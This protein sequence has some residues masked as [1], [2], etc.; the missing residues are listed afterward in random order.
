LSIAPIFIRA[1]LNKNPDGSLRTTNPQ[2][3]YNPTPATLQVNLVALRNALGSLVGMQ[4]GATAISF[5]LRGAW[6]TGSEA[7]TC[8]F[9][10][11]TVSGDTAS[12]HNWSVSGS[13][14]AQSI[15]TGS[16]GA[17]V[18]EL[19]AIDSGSHVLSL[20][21]YSWTILAATGGTDTLAPT[22]PTGL[23]LTGGTGVINAVMDP[24]SDNYDNGTQPSGLD[25]Y[26]VYLDGSNVVSQ[27]VAAVKNP[28][29]QLTATNIGNI[30]SPST[31]TASQTAGV[32][33]LSAAG[34]GFHQT[35]TE[36]CLFVGAPLA[37]DASI[38][39]F[40]DAFT[41]ANVF[42]TS[43]IMI[44]ES[45]AQG[46]I[47]ASLY[48][49]PNNNA[50]GWQVKRRSAT[51]GSG[52]NVAS[53]TGPTSGWAR[54]TRLG[55]A[56]I[57]S[58]SADGITFTDQATISLPMS[59]NAFLG[60]VLASQTA[61]T[62]CNS[63]IREVNIN[64]NPK[65]SF[66]IT[67][68]GTHTVRV[69]AADFHGNISAKCAGVS[70]TAG[71]VAPP[72]GSFKFNPGPVWWQIDYNQNYSTQFS[73]FA[74]FKNKVPLTNGF[75]VEIPWA[76]LENPADPSVIPDT[77]PRRWDGSW[78]TGDQTVVSN[79]RGF[80]LIDSLLAEA[81]RLGCRLCLHMRGVGGHS[82][83]NDVHS[84]PTGWAPSYLQGSAYGPDTHA[85]NGIWGGLWLNSYPAAAG[86]INFQYYTRWWDTRVTARFKAIGAAYGARYDSAH[87]NAAWF[88]MFGFAA[89]EMVVGTQTGYSDSSAIAALTGPDGLYASL[90]ASWPHTMIRVWYNYF[91]ALSAMDAML[92]S[93]FANKLTVGGPD[94]ANE[95]ANTSADPN[96]NSRGIFRSLTADW[97][98]RGLTAA[99]GN[100]GVRDP[101]VPDYVSLGLHFVSEVEG[102]DLTFD[103]ITNARIGGDNRNI[104]DGVLKHIVQHSNLQ[105]STHI[106]WYPNALAGP[107]KNRINVASPNLYDFLNSLSQGGFTAV[108]GVTA[109]VAL[110]TTT[111]PAS[112]P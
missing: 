6:L 82:N 64:T 41:S 103:V 3:D 36:Q 10:L 51:G 2:G 76:S 101:S 50:L 83:G 108:N 79:Q 63:T 78:A 109:G 96:E 110:E 92:A 80:K 98:A 46:A 25:H 43:G 47:F 97:R 17:G 13:T 102:E 66:S 1:G 19:Q 38:T 40:V 71:S 49:Q 94:T 62:I 112:W 95:T 73:N 105:K 31:P 22:V 65:V 100:G 34:T 68:T 29:V 27:T 45:L 67:T 56:V 72:T 74:T 32:W 26:N 111:Y 60:L 37:G 90:R 48:M 75:E 18:F 44:R 35:P 52:S 12:T 42:S 86:V 33:S 23:V 88:E 57:A 99:L 70:G 14:L 39:V 81:K 104:G 84:F 16:I 4:V 7:A 8:T 89:D 106:F 77:D 28:V 93:A 21:Q 5:N 24:A 54:L 53:V 69:A 85:T 87:A 59:Q 20:G 107:N 61:G 58:T 30:T 91:Q 15:V 11:R 55:S 9:A